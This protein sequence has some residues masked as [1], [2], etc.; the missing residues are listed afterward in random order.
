MDT[1]DLYALRNLAHRLF[2]PLERACASRDEAARL[3]T[4]LGYIAPGPVTAFGKLNAGLGA[5]DDIF[6]SISTLSADSSPPD[7]VAA[8]Q[9]ALQAVKV[10]VDSINGVRPTCRATSLG[11]GFS[12]RQIS[13]R[14]LRAS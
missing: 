8:G 6:E 9:R 10:V 1:D 2:A 5:L 12:R 3:L 13:S 14:S 7:L 4:E 11:P